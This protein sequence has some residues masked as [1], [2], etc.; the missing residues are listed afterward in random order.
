MLRVKEFKGVFNVLWVCFEVNLARSGVGDLLALVLVKVGN[1]VD[2][3]QEQKQSLNIAM[4][5]PGRCM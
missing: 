5:L 4:A 2:K 3:V 1:D